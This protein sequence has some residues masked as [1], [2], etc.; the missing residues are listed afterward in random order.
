MNLILYENILLY[1]SNFYI[2]KK[3]IS[4]T[5]LNDRIS[6]PFTPLDIET[7]KINEEEH[8]VYFNTPVLL[9]DSFHWN[10]A[11]CM[12]N[13]I[14]PSWF[15]LFNKLTDKSE[16]DNFQWIVFDNLGDFHIYTNKNMIETISGNPIEN[17][18]SF[19]NK[20]NKP[21]IIKYLVTGL[22]G[23]GIGHVNKNNLTVSRGLII[24]NIDPIEKFVNRIYYK[25][26]IKRNSLVDNL[27]ICNNIIFIKNKRYMNGIEE[28]FDKLHSKYNG[29]FNFKIIDYSNYNF[30][31]QLN[32]LNKTCICIVGVGSARFNTP[33]LPNGAIEIQT[34]QPNIGRNKCIEYVDYHGGTLS[35]YVKVKNIPYYKEE[36]AINQ[37][38]SHLLEEYIEESINEIPCKFPINLEDNIPKEI[39][40]LI[41]HK[42]YDKLFDEWRNSMSNIIEHF[43][44]ILN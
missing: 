14:Y 28:L 22:E 38:I 32:L 7:I 29:K 19:I 43:I 36:E 1:K 4:T 13:F 35:K 17:I 34:F 16:F 5:S 31:E 44:D 9:L 37:K 20:F 27:D 24:N 30:E 10:P 33:F 25:Y 21:I 11:H 41:N 39:L 42:N 6:K 18:N 2:D 40:N 3:K 26:N 23:I 15:G 8:P 12:W